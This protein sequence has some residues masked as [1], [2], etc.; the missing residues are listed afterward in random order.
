M[1][2]IAATFERLAG[3]NRKALIPYITAGDPEPAATVPTLRALVDNGADIIELGVPFTDPMSDGPVIQQ[4]HERALAQGVVLSDVLDMVRAFR[5]D[6][7]ETPVVL[8]GYLNPVEA[9][10]YERFA[11]ACVEAGVDGL[12]LVDLPPEEA[13]GVRDLLNARGLDL[14]FLI[15][16]T[17]SAERMRRVASAGSGYVYYVSL[18]GVTGSASLDPEAVARQVETIGKTTE[19]P[20][21]VGF[22]IKD[23]ASARAV[24][25]VSDGVVVGSALVRLAGEYGHVPD[26]VPARMGATL[27]AMRSA[28]D[29]HPATDPNHS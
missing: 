20:I 25:N 11:D 27:E 29:E 10:G 16:P 19:L 28:M 13:D 7:A 9:R 1:S 24:A 15:A 14:I 12:L 5:R 21:C 22:G 6:N 23:A 3:E 17:T 4:A 18:K 8:M 2:R 26:Q